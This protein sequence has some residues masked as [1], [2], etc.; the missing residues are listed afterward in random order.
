[1][2]A[3]LEHLRPASRISAL[4]NREPNTPS[5]HDS[6]GSHHEGDSQTPQTSSGVGT[7][8]VRNYRHVSVAC[9]ICR[10]LKRKCDGQ[11]PICSPCAK[12]K[13][14]QQECKYEAS[15]KKRG[16]P[17]GQMEFLKKQ[18]SQ[19][20]LLKRENK[21]FKQ[22]FEQIEKELSQSQSRTGGI[23]LTS[24]TAF[25]DI[26][27]RYFSLFL[28][29]FGASSF[30]CS[31]LDEQ[32]LMVN[33]ALGPRAFEED[34]KPE[35]ST[36]PSVTDSSHSTSPQPASQITSYQIA[37]ISR[38]SAKAWLWK[39]QYLSILAVG[40]RISGD[41]FAAGRYARQAGVAALELVEHQSSEVVKALMI[42][43][44]YLVSC[45][46][47]S[48][49]S[50]YLH[51]A[52]QMSR[53]FAAD[54]DLLYYQS[55]QQSLSTFDA[56]GKKARDRPQKGES[57]AATKASSSST[58]DLKE[59]VAALT[60]PMIASKRQ[61]N[62][63]QVLRA[64]AQIFS[65]NWDF[66]K[67]TAN[68]SLYAALETIDL[69]SQHFDDQLLR[70][71]IN[72]LL[73]I[74]IAFSHPKESEE[75]GGGG[76]NVAS[77][78]SDRSKG[79]T[80]PLSGAGAL[81]VDDPR[82]VT[83]ADAFTNLSTTLEN[84]VVRTSLLAP[85]LYV[86]AQ[87]HL[88]THSKLLGKDL[89]LLTKMA[90]IW[91]FGTF[92]LS[93]LQ[94]HMF[95]QQVPLPNMQMPR[96]N[97]SSV[98]SALLPPSTNANLMLSNPIPPPPPNPPASLMNQMAANFAQNPSSLMPWS[99]MMVP[100]Q[101]RNAAGGSIP[102]PPPPSPQ[103]NLP[104]QGQ[105]FNPMQNN[106]FYA[107]LAGGNPAGPS[108]SML[109]PPMIPS[110][111][112]NSNALNMF[113][114]PR[115]QQSLYPNSNFGQPNMGVFPGSFG[116]NAPKPSNTNG[117]NNVNSVPQQRMLQQSMN[118]F[119]N[120]LPFGFNASATSFM[121]PQYMANAMNGSCSSCGQAVCTCSSTHSH[122][123]H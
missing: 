89:D 46:Q 5:D 86:V 6:D 90:Q 92:P 58:S 69:E 26:E 63:K 20:D 101:M 73:C 48:L 41:E 70:V 95:A 57:I 29:S 4:L 123:P 102:N 110:G 65:N 24:A 115:T 45:G 3:D 77:P 60:Q 32:R 112:Q 91:K 23:L 47:F 111:P 15:A 72:G 62:K 78:V 105:G 96:F 99:N 54:D 7:K 56:W 116:G 82:V 107:A 106:A 40:A 68:S 85:M 87:I 93:W 71:W 31:L 94:E 38:V 52:S 80:P 28:E 34:S 113:F 75:K 33:I 122:E 108:Q 50:V 84:H 61:H 98:P 17:A 49:A 9:T 59:K 12:A 37:D 81:N 30:L 104:L 66:T 35:V 97:G 53:R 22:S 16:P 19:V 21:R 39:L 88:A 120:Q 25:S 36:S 1:M 119:G 2:D 103:H 109:M 14:M 55:V 117:V 76:E 8:R 100:P 67:L 114:D 42:L 18:A 27:H 51:A 79:S 118:M 44:Y 74:L 11:R 43:V 13:Y 83:H 121:M 64:L 10:K